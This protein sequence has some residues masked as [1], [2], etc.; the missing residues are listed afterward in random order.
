MKEKL[1]RNGS[2]KLISLFCAFF[3]WL[4]VVNVANPIK[5]STEEVK[6][7]FINGQVL[8]RANLTYEIVGKSTATISFKVRT[9]DEYKISASDFRAYADLSEMYD[10][11]G[12]IPMRS[13]WSHSRW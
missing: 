4:G 3:V 9:K 6:V 8:E 13:C 2:I 12:A 10:V 5:V 1:T 11:T 7:E